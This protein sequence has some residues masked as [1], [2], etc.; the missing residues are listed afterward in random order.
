[1]LVHSKS[2]LS[3]VIGF[4]L[5]TLFGQPSFPASS[6]NQ[7]SPHNFIFF[8]NKEGFKSERV[9][10]FEQDSCGFIWMGTSEGILRYDGKQFIGFDEEKPQVKRLLNSNIQ[11]LL[12]DKNQN[13]WIGT[14]K[15]VILYNQLD[16]QFRIITFPPKKDNYIT[17]LAQ[18]EK[19]NIWAGSNS[20]VF[21]IDTNYQ[22]RLVITSAEMLKSLCWVFTVKNEIYVI[23]HNTIYVYDFLTKKLL[24]SIRYAP[25]ELVSDNV[26]TY[27]IMDKR[28]NIW[29]GKYN[30]EAYQYNCKKR[31]LKQFDLKQITQNLSALPTKFFC[32]DTNKVWLSIDE[33]GIWYF[34]YHLEKFVEFISQ[35]KTGNLIPSYKISS[36]FI[37]RE[38]NLWFGTGKNGLAMTNNH[39]NI[40][41]K[42]LVVDPIKS[43]IV[44]AVFKDDKKQLWVGTDGG[45]LLLYD[46]TFQHLQSFVHSP[47]VAGS[48]PS[49]AVMSIFQDSKKRLWVGTY[50]GGL[51]LFDKVQNSFIHYNTKQGNES[52]LLKND[53][54]KIT[55]DKNGNLWLVV[56]GKGVACFNPESKTFKNYTDL[57]SL[58]TYDIMLDHEGSV[59]VATNNGVCKK[60]KNEALFHLINSSALN[61][62]MPDIEARCLFE[63]QQNRVWIGTTQGLYYL[64]NN[65]KSKIN[66]IKKLYTISIK[67]ICQDARGYLLISTNRG[68]FRYQHDRNHWDHYDESDGLI[69]NEFIV[70]ASCFYGKKELFLGSSKGVCWFEP[71]KIQNEKFSGFPIIT[72]VKLFNKPLKPS[73]TGNLRQSMPFTKTITFK[74]DENHLI[75]EFANPGSIKGVDKTYFK[76]K[77]EG[78]DKDWQNGNQNSEAVYP[79]LPPGKYILK[80]RSA[81]KFSDSAP[82]YVT[83]LEV[84]ITPPFWETWW[85]K[86]ACILGLLV[87]VYSYKQ[88]NLKEIE[89][90]N[91]FLEEKVD[92]RTVEIRH[93]NQLLEEQQRQLENSNASKDKLFS[94]IAHDLRSPFSAVTLWAEKLYHEDNQQHASEKRSTILKHII[95][96]SKNA[97]QVLENLL[98]WARTQTNRIVFN[99]QWVDLKLHATRLKETYEHK[100]KEK[101]IELILEINQPL[102]AMADSN[103]LETIL[104]NMIDNAIKYANPHG[105]VLIRI[106]QSVTGFLIMVRDNGQGMDASQLQLI[107]TQD[108][109]T[110]TDGTQ[111]EKGTGLGLLLCREFLKYHA[112]SLEVI[113]EKGQGTTFI[114]NFPCEC[115]RLE[116]DFSSALIQDNAVPM[117][118]N[119]ILDKKERAFL[120]EKSVLI[121]EDQIEIRAFIVQ[122][123]EKIFKIHEAA[124]GA[125]ALDLVKDIMPD[126]IISDVVMPQINGLEFSRRIKEDIAT[127]HIPIILLTSQK[128]ESDVIAGL[129]TGVDDYLVKPFNTE[130]LILKI[131]RILWN[132]EQFKKKFR[133]NDSPALEEMAANSVDNKLLQKVFEIIEKNITDEKFGVE[134]LSKE[135]GMH[136]ST[137]SKKITA[138]TNTSPQELIKTHRLKLAARMILASGKTISEVA[139]D[140]G[141]TDPKYFSRSFKAFFGVLPSEYKESIN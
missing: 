45:G 15:D 119:I 69:G 116:S 73:P 53:V 115:I 30:G 60:Q 83:S 18:D 61:K 38:Q 56:H 92:L 124:N 74:Y 138:L 126:I 71:D 79:A 14:N 141:F 89:L 111:G 100:A 93:K 135:I 82:N 103:M 76:Y 137:F 113:S 68:I 63:D 9:R 134:A 62:E 78:L 101:N 36:V 133:L 125:V 131:A 86:V 43:K 85:F 54:R 26:H 123:L 40:F 98:Q 17:N 48:I 84:I 65:T 25:E 35:K 70:N 7:D 81:E 37:D 5:A 29:I 51:S 77:L 50:K 4:I 46:S 39:L 90:K 20:G 1:M 33:A 52:G 10:E 6:S 80:V 110:S 118:R 8:G 12:K 95:N 28:Q 67:S 23:S 87:S 47:Q 75:F 121:V 44:S 127:S 55:E 114:M 97:S 32:N 24:N 140:V 31:R 41:N 3:L 13:I 59:W 27:A 34:D 105:T 96:A 128:E 91:K 108:T 106:E 11:S 136:R 132:R 64:E 120:K 72:N 109:L 19:G 2:I 139:Y 49:N 58:W 122:E 130:I 22:A 88:Y 16:G 104:R 94:I 99:P 117:A 102:K 42:L 57:P 107:K 21:L 66:S 112:A 129:Q